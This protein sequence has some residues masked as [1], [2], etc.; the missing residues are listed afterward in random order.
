MIKIC[1]VILIKDYKHKLTLYN[2]SENEKKALVISENTQNTWQSN[3]DCEEKLGNT[4]QGK[5]AEHIIQSYLVKLRAIKYLDY[6]DFRGDNLKKHSPFDGLIYLSNQNKINQTEV[7][8][9]IK[10]K[11]IK[12]ENSKNNKFITNF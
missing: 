4:K 8:R 7:Y 9:K 12:N 1:D 5:T 3:R 2:D 6:D 11:I 10:K